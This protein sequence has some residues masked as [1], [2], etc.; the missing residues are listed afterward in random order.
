MM[1]WMNISAREPKK[2]RETGKDNQDIKNKKTGLYE[3]RLENKC[4]HS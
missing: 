4:K 3:Y 1:L 2:N